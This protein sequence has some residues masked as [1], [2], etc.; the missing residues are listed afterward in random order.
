[1]STVKGSIG[2]SGLHPVSPAA[3]WGDSSN[4]V[5]TAGTSTM[6]PGVE[7]IST[8][9]AG[10]VGSSETVIGVFGICAGDGVNNSGMAVAGFN[11]V[12]PPYQDASLFVGAWPS[13]VGVIGLS[14][15]EYGV[16]GISQGEAC[17]VFGQ[18]AS[19]IGV[20]GAS[21]ESVGLH[22]ASDATHAIVGYKDNENGVAGLF[23]NFAVV[24]SGNKPGQ[25]QF[26]YMDAGAFDGHVY[27]AGNLHVGGIKGFRIDHP[28][29]PGHKTLTHSAVESADMKNLYD[30]VIRL[31]NKGQGVVRLPKWFSALN[32][33]FRYQLTAL[34]GPAPNLHI[35]K[36]LNNNCFTVG[37]GVPLSRVCWQVTGTRQDAWAKAYPM[38]VE[39]KKKPK[40]RGR[41]AAPH[42]YPEL[43]GKTPES[44]L[45]RR[46]VDVL[47]LQKKSK[48]SQGKAR[49]P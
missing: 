9:N 43:R 15:N 44:V 8:Q 46:L 18:S 6:A 47:V 5:G 12:N 48:R 42:L 22:G 40:D 26:N 19:G 21:S 38:Q 3:V 17:G 11:G 4:S 20:S 2:N 23:S 41:F 35:L 49:R 33:D 14:K 45:P 10:V 30:G 24:G 16:V 34:G 39:E 27:I 25:W 32:K 29:D 28:L 31:N 13:Q 36:E 7:G 37:G 1:M